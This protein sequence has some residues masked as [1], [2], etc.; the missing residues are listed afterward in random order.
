MSGLIIKLHSQLV[1]TIM[2]E[3]SN[4]GHFDS[5]FHMTE[6]SLYEVIPLQVSLGI[7]DQGSFSSSFNFNNLLRFDYGEKIRL[8][9][10]MIM[11]AL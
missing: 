9:L 8:S 5:Y 6:T 10:F 2:R 7:R 3:I 11:T 4:Y 1:V